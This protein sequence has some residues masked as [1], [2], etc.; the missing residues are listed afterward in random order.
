MKVLLHML[1]ST[2]RA[3]LLGSSPREGHLCLGSMRRVGLVHHLD[4]HLVLQTLATPFASSLA[5]LAIAGQYS[6]FRKL[7][8]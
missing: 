8:L 1:L 5:A 4:L 6:A 3:Y 7:G 2:P